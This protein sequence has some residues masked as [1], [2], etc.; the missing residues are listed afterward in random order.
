MLITKQQWTAA[1]QC[2]LDDVENMHGSVTGDDV[3]CAE[4][5]RCNCIRGMTIRL[6][7]KLQAVAV[8]VYNVLEGL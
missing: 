8:T 4:A 1:L 6:L 3:H 2:C 5:S 7:L